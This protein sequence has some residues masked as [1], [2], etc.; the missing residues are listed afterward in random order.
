MRLVNFQTFNLIQ[1]IKITFLI[2]IYAYITLFKVHNTLFK[3]PHHPQNTLF[4][5]THHHLQSNTTPS[6]KYHN[7]IFKVT[8]HHLQ[9]TTTPSSKYHN[10]LFKPSAYQLHC[11]RVKE[12]CRKQCCQKSIHFRS[13]SL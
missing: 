3:V 12:W 13:S 5:V 8:Q 11:V 2:F 4:K 6:L 10:T 1:H 9:S 7:I